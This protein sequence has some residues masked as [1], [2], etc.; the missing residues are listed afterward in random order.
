MEEMGSASVRPGRYAAIDIGTVTCRL[1]V[2]DVILDAEGIPRVHECAKEYVVT[3]LGEGV[4]E[5]A[6]LKPEAIARVAEALRGFVEVRDS[7]NTA[8]HPLLK[9]VTIATSASRDAKN[10]A[11]FRSH[12]E[13]LGLEAAVISGR[14]EAALSFLGVAS[15]LSAA[16]VQDPIMVV[17]VGGGSTEISLGRAGSLPFASHSFDIGCRR[18][19]ERFLRTYPPDPS[20]VQEARA[21]MRQQFAPWL[22]A[23]EERLAKGR[24]RDLTMVAVA[25][26]ATSAVSIRE[27]ME[28][29]DPSRVHGAFVSREDIG[30]IEDSMASMTFAQLEAIKGL[31]PRRAPVIFAGMLILDEVL[32]AADARGFQVSESDILQGA[33]L[34]A[35]AQGG[36]LR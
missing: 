12:L 31:D 33:I 34:D 5:S 8:D 18:V 23:Q 15:G 25:G 19:T 28:P 26:T 7:F 36:S 29:Y 32:S 27:E 16:S 35:A 6:R 20:S 17:D 14:Q 13:T 24:A 3:N 22:R 2:G 11:D 30:T 1:L 10:A 21:W 4:D 9:T